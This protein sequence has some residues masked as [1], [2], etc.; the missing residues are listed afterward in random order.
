M[1][2]TL[3][4]LLR[5]A[6]RRA[7]DAFTAALAPLEIE[8]RHFGVLLSLHRA[9]PQ[10]Q[11]ELSGRTG[12][13]K[14]TMTRTIDELAARGLVVR[15]A[16]ASDRRVNVVELTDAGR[17]RFA[18][19]ERVAA[20]VNDELMAHMTADERDALRHHLRRFLDA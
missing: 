3:G 11:R 4:P 5:R 19:A 13:D 20:E 1:E 7:A 14:S 12:S 18:A 17:E 9:G 8:G 2:Y 15:R 10:N 6:G 16:S